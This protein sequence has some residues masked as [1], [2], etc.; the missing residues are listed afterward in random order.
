MNVLVHVLVNE[1]VLSR[2]KDLA[3]DEFGL[4]PALRG[5]PKTLKNVHAYVHV[6][7]HEH[8][9]KAQPTNMTRPTGPGFCWQ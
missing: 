3:R 5:I 8:Q 9:R 4:L 2:L 6:H 1:G 7:V